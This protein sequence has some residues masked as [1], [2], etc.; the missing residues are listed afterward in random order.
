MPAPLRKACHACRKAKRPCRN[1]L[2]K[3]PRCFAKG[4]KCTYDLEPVT[5][6]ERHGPDPPPHRQL[7]REPFP[8]VVYDSIQ[9]AHADA[10]KNY[11]PDG[12]DPH[13]SLPV[14]SSPE[15]FALAFEKLNEIP[16][17]TFQLR[18]TPFIHSQILSSKWQDSMDH[19]PRTRESQ[20]TST[21]GLTK[22]MEDEQRRLLAL[23]I[24]SL[25]FSDFLANFHRLMAILV[26]SMLNKVR[27]QAEVSAF[28]ALRDL[29]PR[30]TQ[31]FHAHLPRRLD[32]E[33]SAW[34]AWTLAETTR[35][36]II[37]TL[38]VEV[39][40]EMIYRGFFYYR[41]MVESLPFD[42]RTG[43]WEASTEAEWQTAIAEHGGAECSLISWHE[44]IERGGPEPR[45]E[46]DGMLQRL[47]LIG[48]FSKAAVV[49]DAK[50]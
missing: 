8:S 16:F 48:Y 9:A 5:N 43:V 31:H 32:P 35:R 37:F 10:I 42:A 29:F 13:Y 36:T 40:L 2:P 17:A 50:A 33:L 27:G 28:Q 49:H 45:K 34:Q 30:W 6:K 20:L 22:F 39:L 11:T 1:E 41:P 44:F 47:L 4:L 3:C 12:F 25:P 21:T 15:P 26:A 7:V 19:E 14:V 24:E 18:S 23:D 46:Y 38:M